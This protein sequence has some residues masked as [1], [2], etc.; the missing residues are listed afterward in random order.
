MWKDEASTALN[1]LW[2]LQCVTVACLSAGCP[3][4]TGALTALLVADV[5]VYLVDSPG[6]SWQTR[7]LNPGRQAQW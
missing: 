2:L 6:P 3:L 4:G 7:P 5:L 1:L